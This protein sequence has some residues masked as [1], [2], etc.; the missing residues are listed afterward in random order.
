M[1]PVLHSQSDRCWTAIVVGFNVYTGL[2]C[3]LVGMIVYSKGAIVKFGRTGKSA[4]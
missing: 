1:A 2:H 3:L 4:V